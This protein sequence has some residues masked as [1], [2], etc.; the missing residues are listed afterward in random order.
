MTTHPTRGP[1]SSSTSGRCYQ[2]LLQASFYWAICRGVFRAKIVVLLACAYLAYAG[3]HWLHRYVAGVNLR[4][5]WGCS[6]RV[7]LKD[8]LMLAALVL[9]FR[10]PRA[11]RE[12]EVQGVA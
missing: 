11:G 12:Q 8:L 7:L 1:G 6:L 4:V 3:T 5:L 2:G 9:M 10:K